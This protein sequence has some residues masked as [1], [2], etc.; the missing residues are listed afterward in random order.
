MGAHFRLYVKVY[1]CFPSPVLQRWYGCGVG[2]ALL[3]DTRTWHCAMPN[4]TPNAR[5]C[6]ILN[7]CNFCK[8]HKQSA[9][10]CNVWAYFDRLLLL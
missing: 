4:V 7:Y 1:P 9:I 8:L 10:A 3:F 6:M 5:R 2:T